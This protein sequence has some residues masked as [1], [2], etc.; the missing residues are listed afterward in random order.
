MPVRD[1]RPVAE[2]TGWY[3][4]SP[5]QRARACGFASVAGRF[6]APASEV[7]ATLATDGRAS[8]VHPS[9]T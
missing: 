2:A 1:A 7:A 8:P 4:R 6:S 5:L 3:L 9:D